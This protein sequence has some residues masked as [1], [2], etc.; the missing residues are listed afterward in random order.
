MRKI[1][2]VI[3]LENNYPQHQYEKRL[4][5]SSFKVYGPF[6]AWHASDIQFYLL[7]D[8]GCWLCIAVGYWANSSIFH[9]RHYSS[10]KIFFS[11]LMANLQ[12][13]YGHNVK[14]KQMS[15]TI[16]SCKIPIFENNHPKRDFFFFKTVHFSLCWHLLQAGLISMATCMSRDKTYN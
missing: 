6:W 2:L 11:I 12:D 8:S 3:Y 5:T 10:W 7:Q 4:H 1:L 14:Q 13:T 9:C 16:I 15:W